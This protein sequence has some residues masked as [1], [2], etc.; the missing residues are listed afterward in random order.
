MFET[1]VGAI[2]SEENIAYLRPETAQGIFVNFRNV[3][4]STRLKLPFGIAQV[5]KAFRNE[6]NP[7][8]YTFRSR[9]FEQMEIEFFCHPDES[10]KW[11]EYWRDAAQEVV[12][13]ARHQVGTAAAARTGQGG[14]G[15][16][17]DRH[18]GHRIHVPVF[19]GTAGAGRRRPSRRLR[20][21]AAHEAQRQRPDLFRRGRLEPL[22][23]GEQGQAFGGDKKREQEEKA[24]YR[25][26]CRTSSSRRPGRTGSR[27]RCLCE[28]YAE[29]EIGGEARRTR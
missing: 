20:P 15:P 14:T 11:Y 7:R 6:I 26:I 17:F 10:M 1:Y 21:D 9:E 13:A 2:Q 19:R 5:G 16:L 28:A 3:L 23:Q 24:K 18:H 22:D 27:W 25:F 12:H 4:D 8:N 29:D